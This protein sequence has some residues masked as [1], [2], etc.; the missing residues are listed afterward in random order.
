M[1][2][3]RD[4]GTP[5]SPASPPGHGQRSPEAG[6]NL[7]NV[8]QGAMLPLPKVNLTCKNILPLPGLQRDLS[9]EIQLF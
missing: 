7:P 6:D 5:A 2:A 8:A 9:D 4:P 1:G 3:R